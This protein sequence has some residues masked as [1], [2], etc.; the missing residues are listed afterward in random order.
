MAASG[1]P[2]ACAALGTVAVAQAP[3]P[4]PSSLPAELR[5][6]LVRF[7]ERSL[8]VGLGSGSKDNVALSHA[9]P[10]SSAFIRSS[11]EASF[12]RLPLDGTQVTLFL[13]ADDTRYLSSKSVDH[14]TTAFSQCEWRRLLGD[15]WEL[16]LGVEGTYVDQVIDLSVTE[17]NREA[18]LVRGAGVTVRPG[19]RRDWSGRWW[20]ALEAPGA[21]HWFEETVDDSWQAGTKLTIGRS[22]AEKSE[23]NLSH[24]FTWRRGDQAPARD[25]AGAAITNRIRA[26]GQ[27]D[28]MLAWR[29]DWDR[30]LRWRSV[31]KLAY[32]NSRDNGGGYFDY[33][34]V[35]MS[36]QLRFRTSRWTLS[37]EARL[38]FYYYPIQTV[39]ADD[40]EK[41]QRTEFAC[42]ARAEFKLAP[43]LRLFAQFDREKTLSNLTLDEYTSNTFSGGLLLEF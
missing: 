7:W 38:G 31:T 6:P 9:A 25:A 22:Y 17:T 39:A 10:E 40:P 16:G 35:Q 20:A 43:L 24:E 3:D 11:L 33:R 18:V 30:Q 29:H 28:F 4:L 26:D 23:V 27:H 13:G 34:R 15:G 32:R 41:R 5:Q 21:S 2:F 36:E 1:L 12:F 8:S 42:S 37:V 14:E 19:A